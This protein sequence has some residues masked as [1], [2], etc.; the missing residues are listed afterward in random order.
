MEPFK[1]T[2]KNEKLKYYDR[3]AIFI[4]FINGI[5]ISIV[6][7]RSNFQKLSEGSSGLIA[8][9]IAITSLI[10]ALIHWKRKNQNPVLL[11]SF[12]IIGFWIVT[13]QWVPAIIIS[14]LIYLY[15]LAKRP[16]LVSVEN[17]II[18]YPSFPKKVINWEIV[19]NIILK[20]DLLTIDLK[21]NKI[22][23]QYIE[24][25]ILPFNEQEFNDFCIQQL[26][27]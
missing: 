18:I 17:D 23:Q 10:Y 6:I 22:Y 25:K 26:N 1:M 19:N 3:F 8:L 4:Y 21:N 24:N 13:Q 14:I 16:L 5:A 2:L 15:Y 7:S 12:G 27:K 9:I 20:D 11:A